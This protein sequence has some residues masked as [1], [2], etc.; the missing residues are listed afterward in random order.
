MWPEINPWNVMF[1][2]LGGLATLAF[3]VSKNN[4]IECEWNSATHEYELKLRDYLWRW[5]NYGSHES[6]IISL[7]SSLLLPRLLQHLQLP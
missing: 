7:G 3:S 5:N 6:P 1:S 2:V 4:N